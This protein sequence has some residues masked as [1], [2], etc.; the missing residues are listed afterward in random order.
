MEK[1]T[2]NRNQRAILF[3]LACLSDKVQ[4]KNIRNPIPV[5]FWYLLFNLCIEYLSK[6]VIKNNRTYAIMLR[7]I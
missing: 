3:F 7:K 4:G 6:I 1:G 5:L 2:K